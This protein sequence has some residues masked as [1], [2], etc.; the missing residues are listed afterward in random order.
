MKQVKRILD[1]ILGGICVLLF[2]SL[3]C[4]VFWQV[5]SRYA[6]KKP[7]AITEELAKIIFV[8]MVLIAAAFLF[9]EVGGHMNIGIIEEKAGPKRKDLLNLI[10]QIVIFIFALFVLVLGGSKAVINGLM[11]SNAAI[12]SITTGQIYMAL[13]ICGVF[14]I[15]YTLYY[16]VEDVRNL[17]KR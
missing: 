14:T 16:I 13:P 3:T 1:K 5:I 9:G 8:W 10:S 6:L 4:T 12:S 11:Q 7:S 15:F 17:V 2:A